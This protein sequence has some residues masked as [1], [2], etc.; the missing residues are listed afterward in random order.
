[1]RQVLSGD[2]LASRQ[3][4]SDIL[5][6]V[7]FVAGPM[8]ALLHYASAAELQD[9]ERNPAYL[10]GN[11]LLHGDAALPGRRAMHQFTRV[12]GTNARHDQLGDFAGY[13]IA[14]RP[15]CQPMIR[16]FQRELAAI[17][18]TIAQRNQARLA[19]FIHLMPS[20]ICNGITV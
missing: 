5:S 16:Q 17:E 15:E 20:R 11:P 9:M 1:M 10:N 13:A 7:L 4:L 19:P 14:K 6:Q 3:E 2:R 12:M 18:Q 8:H